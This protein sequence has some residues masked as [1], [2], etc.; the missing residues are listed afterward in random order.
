MIERL[1]IALLITVDFVVGELMLFI[2]D[3]PYEID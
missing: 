3:K 1:W 2:F